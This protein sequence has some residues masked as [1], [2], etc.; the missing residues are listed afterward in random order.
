MTKRKLLFLSA[1]LV[2][3]SSVLYADELVNSNTI[4]SSSKNSTN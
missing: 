1:L 2:L 3:T 4:K